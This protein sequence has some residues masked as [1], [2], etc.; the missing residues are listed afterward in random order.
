MDDSVQTTAGLNELVPKVYIASRT[1]R[2]L[3]QLVKELKRSGYNPKFTVLG[4][5]QHYCINDDVKGALDINEACKEALK[6]TSNSRMDGEGY[7]NKKRK[8]RNQNERGQCKY[9]GEAK[10]RC[11]G[12]GFTPD[13][14]MEELLK[15]GMKHNG[16]ESRKTSAYFFTS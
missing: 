2:Q 16:T 8:N 9:V 4:S 3:T 13:M 11:Q 15:F 10:R 6:C 14:D 7:I 12:T 5:R 1:H